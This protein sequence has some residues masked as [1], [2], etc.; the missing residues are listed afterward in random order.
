MII[1]FENLNMFIYSQQ[2]VDVN[3]CQVGRSTD[4]M[5]GVLRYTLPKQSIWDKLS[6]KK[7]TYM[8][9]YIYN[10]AILSFIEP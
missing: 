1:I 8:S 4:S 2:N 5:V 6:I 3:S 7:N 10:N 9:E